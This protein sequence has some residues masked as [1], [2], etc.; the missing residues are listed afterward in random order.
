MVLSSRSQGIGNGLS[1]RCGTDVLPGMLVRVPL[2]NALVEGIV[3]DV[4]PE[5]AANAYPLKDIAAV[6]HAKPLLS[7]ALVKTARWMAGYYCCTLRHVLQTLLP[8]P[9]WSLLT[10]ATTVTYALHASREGGAR[11]GKRQQLVLEYLQ[12]RNAVSAYEL[13]QETGATGAVL[14]GLVQRGLLIKGERTESEQP[15]DFSQPQ[16]PSADEATLAAAASCEADERPTLLIDTGGI[17]RTTLY[18]TLIARQI[19]AGHTAI[20]LAADV[21]SAQRLA[22]RLR[23]RLG[24][25]TLLVHGTQSESV[26]RRLWRSMQNGAPVVVGTR[27]ALFS[28]MASLGLVI[29]DDEHEWTY[30]NEQAPRYHARLAAEVL[31]KT[32]DAKLVLCSA[33]PSL[34]SWRHAVGT[35]PR[36][37]LVH[38]GEQTSSPAIR[39]VDLAQEVSGKHY[40]L[41]APLIAAVERRLQR[42]EQAVLLINRRGSATGLLC[43]DCRKPLTSKHTTLPLPVHIIGGKPHLVD[44]HAEEVLPIPESCPHCQSPRLHAIGAGTQR[45]EQTLKKLFPEARV[46]RVDRDTLE[47]ESIGSVLARAERGDIDIL[48]GTQP[49]VKAA[50]LPNVTLGAVLVADI[51]LSLPHFRAGERVVQHIGSLVRRVPASPQAEVLLQTF[52]PEAPE[53]AL[54]A[55]RSI[56]EYVDSEL[57]LRA[58]AGYPP[59]TQMIRL[60]VREGGEARA[61]LL[62]KQANTHD[63]QACTAWAAAPLP[64]KRGAKWCVFLKGSNPRATLGV[65]DL[66]GVSID[67]DPIDWE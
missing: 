67:V 25:E 23:Q 14:R 55:T 24:T 6:V 44:Q 48:V 8:A 27:T 34:E 53:I 45:V 4:R 26:Q 40:P 1:Y 56:A 2:R 52:R 61:H 30:K 63:P 65:L 57:R 3:M 50:D 60:I 54:S 33:T 29:V 46:A 28:P 35:K 20:V 13:E 39:V 37:S 42:K 21:A 36:F 62:A 9:P 15:A 64:G 18:A 16:E 10:P 31:C 38:A 22:A 43:L 66:R 5:H 47:E 49:V 41:S 12:G 32:S 58:E 7:P 51:G 59:I 19:R 11:L 17:D